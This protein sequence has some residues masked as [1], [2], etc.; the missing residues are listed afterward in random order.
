M[1]LAQRFVS[2]HYL[3]SPV[4]LHSSHWRAAH[5][6][7]GPCHPGVKTVTLTAYLFTSLLSVFF[8]IKYVMIFYYSL[9]KMYKDI[10]AKKNAWKEVASI[11]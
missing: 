7:R 1:T 10:T 3:S 5:N 4:L 11:F 9:K 8:L 2:S 6:S